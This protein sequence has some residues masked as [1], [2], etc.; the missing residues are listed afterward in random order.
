M[1]TLEIG[2]TFY[3][4]SELNAL[5]NELKQEVITTDFYFGSAQSIQAYSSNQTID[6]KSNPEGIPY[7]DIS[8]NLIEY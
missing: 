1:F 6:L 5:I 8:F 3:T 7:W 2:V 4:D